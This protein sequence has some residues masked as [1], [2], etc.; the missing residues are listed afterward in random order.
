MFTL[1][2]QAR[3][4]DHRV[5]S[6]GVVADQLVTYSHHQAPSDGQ[7]NDG[8][9]NGPQSNEAS[10]L[11]ASCATWQSITYS[12]PI[13][14]NQSPFDV[15]LGLLRPQKLGRAALVFNATTAFSQHA[16]PRWFRL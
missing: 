13:V 8:Q 16:R 4:S 1:I 2:N 11:I 15:F 3:G 7:S 10:V 9:S 14:G 5:N 12:L 6:N